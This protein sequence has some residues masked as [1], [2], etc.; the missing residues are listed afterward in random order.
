MKSKTTAY[1]L[2]FLGLFGILGLHRFYL[3]KVGTGILYLLTL[4]LVGV[5]ATIDLFTLGAQVDRI[6]TDIE[7]KELRH[8]TR[9]IADMG[10]DRAR[11][12]LDDMDREESGLV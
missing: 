9:A 6:N 12:E 10:A 3:G 5:G 1:L 11:R 8:T 2:W 7:M 4:G